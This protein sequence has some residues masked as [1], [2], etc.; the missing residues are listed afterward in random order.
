MGFWWLSFVDHDRP[1]GKRQIGCCIVPGDDIA[2]AAQMAWVLKCNPGG[3]VAGI[4]IPVEAEAQ[5]VPFV[6]R[7][8]TP[9]ELALFGAIRVGDAQ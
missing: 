6:G 2:D 1:E 8:L 5:Y 9:A 3:E 4:P 7:I